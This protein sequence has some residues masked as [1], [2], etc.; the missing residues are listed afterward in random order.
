MNKKNIQTILNVDSLPDHEP[1]RFSEYKEIQ[2]DGKKAFELKSGEQ[3]Y[4]DE[5]GGWTDEQGCYYTQDGEADGWFV[6]CEDEQLHFYDIDGKYLP[7]DEEDID[8]LPEHQKE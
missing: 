6:K 2:N 4:L 5:E 3:F 8:K 1:D 7:T